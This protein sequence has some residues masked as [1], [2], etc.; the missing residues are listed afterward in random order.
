[1]PSEETED[2]H[3]HDKH[4]GEKNAYQKLFYFFRFRK[5]G[6]NTPEER[7]DQLEKDMRSNWDELP[8]TLKRRKE[9]LSHSVLAEFHNEHSPEN[10]D[11]EASK[12]HQGKP[13]NGELLL[14]REQINLRELEKLKENLHR[15]LS[16]ATDL[17]SEQR[18]VVDLL[19]RAVSSEDSLLQETSSSS[20]S[21]SSED[22]GQQDSGTDVSEVLGNYEDV[23]IPRKGRGTSK[24]AEDATTVSYYD[25]V[26][27]ENDEDEISLPPQ[28]TIPKINKDYVSMDR[29]RAIAEETYDK[30][31][32][33]RWK[34]QLT[35]PP[36]TMDTIVEEEEKL[37]VREILRRFEMLGSQVSPQGENGEEKSAT[38]KQIQE[39]LRCLEEKVRI[40]E[41]G[42]TSPPETGGDRTPEEQVPLKYVCLENYKNLQNNLFTL[43]YLL[44]DMCI[45]F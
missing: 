33:S 13:T 27:R 29:L 18:H 37:S 40:H 31:R 42:E 25:A 34:R 43:F 9:R 19:R 22:Q 16:S 45:K 12:N 44:L 8:T 26:V 30:P 38:L 39:T 20:T 14:L 41:G 7:R 2:S 5:K 6:K 11:G 36:R 24:S 1:M 32:P 3:A 4:G 15:A 35:E 17:D 21:S 23:S 28:I 10:T